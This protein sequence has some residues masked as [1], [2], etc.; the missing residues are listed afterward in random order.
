[1]N[2]SDAIKF[3]RLFDIGDLATLANE[4]E[5]LLMKGDLDARYLASSFSIDPNESVEAFDL[6]RIQE[7]EALASKWHRASL[8]DLAWAYRHGDDVERDMQKFQNLMTAAA[9]LGDQGAVRTLAE[10][11][12]FEIGETG[13]GSILDQRNG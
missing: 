4:L 1:M 12:E 8:I 10:F 6:R 2:K 7:L 3:Q 13:L 11:L 5:P 9:L